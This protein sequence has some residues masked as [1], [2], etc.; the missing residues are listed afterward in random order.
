MG[1]PVG[2]SH[3]K[4]RILFPGPELNFDLEPTN[5]TGEIM[6]AI[7]RAKQWADQLQSGE[8]LTLRDIARK[9]G[10]SVARISQLLPLARLKPAQ[11]KQVQSGRRPSL[12]KLIQ[13]ARL[14]EQA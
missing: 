14:P 13:C 3:Q 11:I 6:A 7:T 8:A 5:S 9:E 2:R 12:R 10:L 4:P 1:F